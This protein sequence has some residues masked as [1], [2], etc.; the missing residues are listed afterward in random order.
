MAPERRS[1]RQLFLKIVVSAG[2]M[3]FLLYKIS[4]PELVTAVKG[5]DRKM[6]AAAVSAFFVSNLLGAF[7]WHSLLKAD[8]VQLGYVRA[9]RFYFVGLFFNNFLPANIGGDAVKVW[10]V[11]RYG[12]GV[13]QV[14]AVTLLDRIIGIFCLCL[15]A[16]LS[17]L[18]LMADGPLLPYGWYLVIFAGCM[19][20]ALG[21]YFFKP[22]GNL[23][24]AVVSR[25]RPLSI[26]TRM[27][28]ILDHLGAFKA[29]KGLIVRLIGLSLVI[30]VLRVSTHILVGAALGLPIG[31]IVMCQFFVFVPLLSLA[32]IPPVTINGLGV[33]EGLGILLFAGAGFS[34]TDAFTLEFLTYGVSV[35]VSL[36]GL[37]FFLSRRG[38]PES[39]V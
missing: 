35:A 29:R 20:P 38:R 6:L 24:R 26:D 25:I 17:A 33:R 12:G 23:V 9:F 7:Q 15:L 13:Y 1:R 18:Y 37:A 19:A 30:Q 3:A 16:T 21:L 27:T 14:I 5:L 32:M 2:L 39:G 11:S 28:A 10:D 31:T 36:L 22:L 8:G 4:L 34:R